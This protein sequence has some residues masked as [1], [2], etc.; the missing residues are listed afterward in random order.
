MGFSA[1]ER[2]AAE[3]RAREFIFAYERWKRNVG[4]GNALPLA[5]TDLPFRAIDL[6]HTL[7]GEPVPGTDG[8]LPALRP[9]PGGNPCSA[10]ERLAGQTTGRYKGEF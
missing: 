3:G 10:G 7:M 4:R 5:Q 1:R 2:M 8:S 6:V 9:Q